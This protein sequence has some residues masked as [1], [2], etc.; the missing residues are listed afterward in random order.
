MDRRTRVFVMSEQGVRTRR[1]TLTGQ[2]Q[3]VG[4][5]PF[6]YRV[7]ARLFVSGTVRN[8]PGGV[9]IIAAAEPEILDEFQR[10]LLEDAPALARPEKLV[11]EDDRAGDPGFL[12]FRIIASAAGG[13]AGRVTVDTGCCIDCVEELFNEADRRHD[14]ALLNCTGCG[15]RYTIATGTPWDRAKTTMAEFPLCDACRAE[16]EDPRD[17]RFHA[18]PVCCPDCGPQ[19]GLGSAADPIGA[20]L[21]ILESGGIL[22]VKG[23]G[24]YHLSVDARDDDAV[25]R[26]RNLKGRDRKPFA[27]MVR[28]LD[29]ARELVKL[30]V[31]AGSLLISPEAPIVLAERM[32]EG[33]AHSVAFD[34]HL[35]GVMLPNTPIQHVLAQGI[36]RPLVMT[37][38]NRTDDPLISDDEAADEFNVDGTL[39][40][41]R[42]I[43]RAVDDSVFAD[44]SSGPVPV[45]RARGYVPAPIGLPLTAAE[46]GLAVGGDQ[47]SVV[48]VV[49][50][51]EAILSQHLGDLE[52]P[53]AYRRF[54]ETVADL[55]TLF[56][57]EPRWIAA[58][59]H[60]GYRSRKFAEEMAADLGIPLH[61]VQHHH[62]HLTAAMA[63]HGR[64]SPTVGLTLDGVGY[65]EDGTS[66]GGEVLLGDFREFKRL[67]HLR[68]LLL[69]G[70]D[71][72][73]RETGRCALAW[74]FD[75]LG[76]GFD[77][78][79]LA[80]RAIP[81]PDRRK[82]LAEMLVTGIRCPASSGA[83]R[84]F[85]AAASLTS[86]CTHNEFEAMSGMALESAAFRARRRP[87]GQGVIPL[88]SGSPFQMDHRPLLEA[89]MEMLETGES[90]DDVA[91]FFHD[92]L[93]D[94]LSR[95][96]VRAAR[97]SFCDTVA[98]T[99]GVFQ[100]GVLADLV[101]TRLESAG[102]SPLP[103]RE[104][105][106]GDG[107]LA[108]GQAAVGAG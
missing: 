46:P 72:A 70:G 84:L 53:E 32:G 33:V 44:H 40:H 17:R 79:P 80:L 3:G 23:L 93:A 28:D 83:G 103:H 41:N 30:S 31:S 95:A 7:A 106:P 65:G 63:E 10:C 78:H 87:S 12:D 89:M 105:P 64:S 37:S 47:K 96:A 19:L 24:G 61:L 108:L 1:L 51:N 102:L 107:G 48:A 66:W 85:D 50:G 5:R 13:P 45:R 74:L 34:S 25:M 39:S 88:T 14:H 91:W 22:A 62:A 57:I 38:L 94:V 6:V 8:H 49:R 90:V 59:L 92:A 82:A 54:R 20:A 21:E 98:L 67:G 99:G 86:L 27:I 29:A 100:N 68:P 15:P 55:L 26:L 2:V 52:H 4:F 35:L 71:A 16:Y 69:P 36:D 97:A 56:E 18:E 101:I 75:Y 73:A 11:V 58:D 76:A 104:V 42:K 9:S 81:N 60:P 43:E 77:E